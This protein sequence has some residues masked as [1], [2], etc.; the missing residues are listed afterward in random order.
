MKNQWK[1]FSNLEK[2]IGIFLIINLFLDLINKYFLKSTIPNEII[3]YSFWLS[4][5]LFLGFKSCKFYFSKAIKKNI[6]D[7]E[8]KNNIPR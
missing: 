2:S 6:T 1:Q 7:P 4:L 8:L 3:G 5:G